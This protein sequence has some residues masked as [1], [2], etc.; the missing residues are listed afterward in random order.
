MLDLWI[1]R[2]TNKELE[3]VNEQRLA[4]QVRQIKINKW[5]ETVEQEE[6]MIKRYDER[7]Q[8]FKQNQLFRTN[9][10]LFHETLDGKKSE[11]I[12]LPDPTEVATFWR[13]IW[14]EGVSHNEQA[15]WLEDVEQEFS[16]IEV[17]E[18]INI[19]V[20]GIR[21][22]LSNIANW[23]AA[24]PD[25]VQGYWFKKL[26]GCQ[27]C[28]RVD[29]ERKNGLNRLQESIRHGA[30]FM[31]PEMPGD[32]WREHHYHNQQYHGELEDIIDIWRNRF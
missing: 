8:Q 13:K 1:V 10:K 12:G 30:T 18:D 29:G 6:I 17:Q 16:L 19:T 28:T 23:K 5:L 24:G 7:C 15:S 32:G 11:E 14:S 20:E 22:V 27:K 9:Q 31:D 26:S 25:L 21:T 2:N 3:K 4:D